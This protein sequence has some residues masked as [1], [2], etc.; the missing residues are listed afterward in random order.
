MYSLTSNKKHDLIEIFKK[1]N[2]VEFGKFRLKDG[3][4]SSV[5][6]DLRIL[7]NFP[8]EFKLVTNIAV[9]YLKK[10]G[11]D[12]DFEGIIA[13]PI[14]GI[15]LGLAI[16]LELDKSFYLARLVPKSHG[17]GKLIEGNVSGKK[18]L[19]VDDV[20]TSGGSKTPLIE[21]VRDNNA[22]VTSILVYVDRFHSN[23]EKRR[24]E[25]ENNVK[26]HTLLSLIDLKQ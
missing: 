13:P 25:E 9:S 3:S 23:E 24:Y 7:P 19:I 26:I 8:K 20:I 17:T 6:I 12:K 18:L 16:A 11:L 14:A 2:V 10:T 5:Y 21:I 4:T 15:P 22:Q 1:I